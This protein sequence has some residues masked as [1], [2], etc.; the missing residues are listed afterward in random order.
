MR[1]VFLVHLVLATQKLVNRKEYK[2]TSPEN[3]VYGEPF[4]VTPTVFRDKRM[5]KTDF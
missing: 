5:F 3:G 1:S 2:N 4:F